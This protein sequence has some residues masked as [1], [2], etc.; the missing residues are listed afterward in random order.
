VEDNLYSVLVLNDLTYEDNEQLCKYINLLLIELPQ[1][2]ADLENALAKTD[3]NSTKLVLA[4]IRE[5][6]YFFVAPVFRKRLKKMLSKSNVLTI[7]E[8]YETALKPNLLLLL[9]ELEQLKAELKA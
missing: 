7:A 9:T 2:S 5:I 6:S 8:E 3:I 4:E 1:K